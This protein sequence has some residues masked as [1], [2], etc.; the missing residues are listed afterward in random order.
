M[1][2]GLSWRDARALLPVDR[3][4]LPP[5]AAA[6]AG[7]TVLPLVAPQLVRRFV[8]EAT[9]GRAVHSLVLLA[10]AYLVVSGVGRVLAIV[11]SWLASGLAWTATNALRERLAAHA[12]GLD[13]AYHWAH[14]PGEMIERVDGDVTGLTEFLASFV[15]QALGSA[16][17]LAGVLVVVWFE[18]IRIGAVLSVLVALS[19]VALARAQRAVVPHAT[20]L[21]EAHGE[22]FGNLEERLV[23]VDDIRA[24]GAGRHVVRRFLDDCREVV[25]AEAAWHRTGGVVMALTQF[26]FAVATAVLV[27]T[28]V[29]LARRGEITIGTVVLLFQYS[30]M[31]RRPVEQILGQAKQLQ[32]AGAAAARVAELFGEQPAVVEQPGAAPLPAGPLAVAL[33][34]V[35]FAYDDDEVVLHD[36]DLAVV[37]GRSL[38]LVGATGSGKTTIARLLLRFV[39]AGSGT[40]A[41]GGRDIRSAT[42]A[43]LRQRVRLVTQDVQLFD[44]DVRDN[45]TLFDAEVPDHDVIAALTTVGLGPWLAGLPAGLDTTMGAGGIG[46]SA[47]E[48]Q[49]VA[50]ARVFVAAPGLVVL[51]EPAS[52]LDPATEVLVAAATR[53]LLHDRTAVV[54]AHRP[55]SLT[56]VDDVAVLAGGR[57]IEHGARV[58]LAADPRSAY[59]Q[60]MRNAE[61]A[62]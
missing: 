30:L 36:I 15:V 34:H 44:A 45:V 58:E 32:Q 42:L 59:S 51:D 21:R 54:I 11:T 12:L 47:G 43:S 38:A 29:I 53:Q 33:D 22:M 7:S 48:A 31:V 17:L 37:A 56:M 61:V 25:A 52:R 24:N 14:P 57:V 40:V 19:V 50:L 3:R 41:I 39:E 35:S 16:L 4:R 28:G 9:A 2:R 26:L 1:S 5:L 27:G 8:D 49:L 10:V 46:L 62:S 23:A 13:L 20:R 18:D 6:L 55:N 60:L